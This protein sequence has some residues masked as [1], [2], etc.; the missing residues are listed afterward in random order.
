M[1]LIAVFTVVLGQGSGEIHGSVVDPSSAPLGRAEVQITRA[2]AA[3]MM[4]EGNTGGGTGLFR[5]GAL[6]PGVYRLRVSM[7]GFLTQVVDDVSVSNGRITHLDPI[8]LRLQGCDSPFLNCDGF[9]KRSAADD[10]VLRRDCSI[11]FEKPRAVTC[12]PTI[13]RNSNDLRHDLRF[14][15]RNSQLF[16]TALHGPALSKINPENLDCEAASYGGREAR[17]DA[18]G[19]GFAL[20]ACSGEGRAYRIYF[21]SGVKSSSTEIEFRLVQLAGVRCRASAP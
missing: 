10:I 14:E 15:S 16:F 18:L 7:A 11:D 13:L 21:M 6:E 8:M 5:S 4:L 12:F 19:P 3:D 17:I 20:C 2:G 9:V 1:L